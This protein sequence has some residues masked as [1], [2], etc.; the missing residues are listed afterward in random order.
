[1]DGRSW[2]PWENYSFVLYCLTPFEVDYKFNLRLIIRAVNSD[3]KENSSWKM[4][5]PTSMEKKQECE[6]TLW[7]YVFG[8]S[9]SLYMKAMD[10]F[11]ICRLW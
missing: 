3:S 11:H 1:M 2:V 4:G 10:W 6:K 8:G 9:C 7:N 5:T